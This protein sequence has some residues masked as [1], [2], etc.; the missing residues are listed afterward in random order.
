MFNENSV[1]SSS[2]A[3]LLQ[4]KVESSML[5]LVKQSLLRNIFFD[6]DASCWFSFFNVFFFSKIKFQGTLGPIYV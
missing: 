6:V 3:L 1:P 2:S 4:Q 5:F